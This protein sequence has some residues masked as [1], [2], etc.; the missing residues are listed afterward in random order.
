MRYPG[1]LDDTNRN[2]SKPRHYLGED[3]LTEK[4]WSRTDA[5]GRKFGLIREMATIKP[6]D[7]GIEIIN[8]T[9]GSAM[10]CF[11]MRALDSCLQS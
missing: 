4:H 10:T 11:P 8:A 5:Q 7:Y 3:V 6:E 9:P 1:K 2:Y